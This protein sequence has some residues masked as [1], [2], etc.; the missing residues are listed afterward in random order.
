MGERIPRRLKRFNREGVEPTKEAMKGINENKFFY[1]SEQNESK[2]SEKK[3]LMSS[4]EMLGEKS[5]GKEVLGKESTSKEIATELA[6]EEVQ[7]FKDK[8]QRLPEKEEY[9]SISE[10]IYAQLKDKEQRKK[11]SNCFKL[12]K[13][14]PVKIKLKAGFGFILLPP[15]T[16]SPCKPV[17]LYYNSIIV[18]E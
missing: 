11:A 13:K 8:H 16:V 18:I 9:E 10:S 2:A 1:D 12:L 14:E 15:K 5:S 3:N 6:L 7:R 4:K 17:Y